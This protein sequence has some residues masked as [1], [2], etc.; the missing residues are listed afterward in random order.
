VKDDTF[1]TANANNGVDYSQELTVHYYLSRNTKFFL[2]KII[3]PSV[4]LAVISCAVFLI[5]VEDVADRLAYAI[6]GFL[7]AF[8]L[9][10]VIGDLI[11][12]LDFLTVID[13]IVLGALTIMSLGI[14]ATWA[15]RWMLRNRSRAIAEEYNVYFGFGMVG[16]FVVL[17]LGT[18]LPPVLSKGSRYRKI[19][20]TPGFI[21]AKQI[22]TK[23]K[24]E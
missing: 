3:Y 2:Y 10:F 6:T 4:L 23:F 5:D 19:A 20:A 15:T 7:A 21:A 22:V 17:V 1:E 18:L 16:L 13:E 8:A 9:L 14:G 24:E 12:K 11:P